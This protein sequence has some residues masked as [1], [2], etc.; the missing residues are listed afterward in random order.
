[1]HPVPRILA[2]IAL[3][4]PLGGQDPVDKPKK[5][6]YA[7]VVNDKNPVKETGDEAKA[8]VRKLFLKELTQWPGSLDAK[9]YGREAASDEQVAFLKIVLQLTDS[10]LARHWLKQKNLNG[11]TPP[12]EVDSDRMVLKYVARTTGA[13]GIVR[14]DAIKDTPGVRILFTF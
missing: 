10:E 9:P 7:V 2:A 5:A 3:L 4:V 8:L 12:K 6:I 1:M 14:I 11:T 13:F